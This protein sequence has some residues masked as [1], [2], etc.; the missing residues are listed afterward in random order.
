MVEREGRLKKK[1]VVRKRM[2]AANPNPKEMGDFRAGQYLGGSINVE[3]FIFDLF[4]PVHLDS[5]QQ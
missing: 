5:I 3:S 4:E 1:E 2:E